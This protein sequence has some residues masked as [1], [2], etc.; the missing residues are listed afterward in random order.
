MGI[1]TTKPIKELTKSEFKEILYRREIEV[2]AH[3]LD[4]LS[5]SQRKVF[6]EEELIDMLNKE[7]A[8]K[9]YLQEN[10]RYSAY[11]RR[12]DGYRRLMIE[13]E[14]E[15]VV[16]VSFINVDELPRVELE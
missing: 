1:F 6:K 14:K 7:N 12:K 4:H 16:I 11:Y 15:K 3:A 9:I 13:L 2:S 10:G 5:A 8:R